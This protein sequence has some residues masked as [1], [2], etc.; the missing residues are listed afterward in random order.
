M[1]VR[2]IRCRILF[3]WSRPKGGPPKRCAECRRLRRNKL[4]RAGVKRRGARD[5]AADW[6]RRK[7]RAAAK[8]DFAGLTQLPGCAPIGYLPRVETVKCVHCFKAVATMRRGSRGCC[9]DCKA[10]GLR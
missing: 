3:E 1:T 6:A 10:K 7:A 4:E 8:Q 2:C 5:W 9:L